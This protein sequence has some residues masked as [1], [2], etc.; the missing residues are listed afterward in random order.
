MNKKKQPNIQKIYDDLDVTKWTYYYWGNPINWFR[1]IKLYRHKR[2]NMRERAQY[3][4][5][6]LDGYNVQTGLPALCYVFFKRLLEKEISYYNKWG[7]SDKGL[8]YGNKDVIV[9][10]T[11]IV[12]NLQTLASEDENIYEKLYFESMEF[13]SK[14]DQAE[15]HKVYHA[16]QERLKEKRRRLTEETYKMIGEVLPKI[17][18]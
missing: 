3:G 12:Y 14:V 1:N 9:A 6:H 16:E 15:V 5:C 7:E 11:Q 17:D 8:H 18:W 4:S 13:D 10:L 2:R